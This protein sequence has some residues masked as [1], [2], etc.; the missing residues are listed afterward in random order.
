MFVLGK[1]RIHTFSLFAWAF[2]VFFTFTGYD[3][4]WQGQPGVLV[5]A[6]SLSMAA[7]LMLA[8]NVSLWKKHD[9]ASVP[10]SLSVG[11]DDVYLSA[12]LLMARSSICVIKENH[13]SIFN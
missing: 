12:I 10:V 5:A 13:H 7:V 9:P 3:Q 8:G 6:P 4:A 2:C 1:S 11:V